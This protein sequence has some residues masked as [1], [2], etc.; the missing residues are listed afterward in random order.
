MKIETVSVQLAGD[1]IIVTMPGTSYRA[2][3]LK[4]PDWPGLMQSGRMRDDKDA[5]L[6]P[7]EFLALAWQAADAKGREL[8]WIL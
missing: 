3:Y 2:T 5:A 6:S 1:A 8:G 7:N 4:A